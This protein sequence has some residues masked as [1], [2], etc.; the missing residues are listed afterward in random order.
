MDIIGVS[1]INLF[2]KTFTGKVS[3]GILLGN[4]DTAYF[5]RRTIFVPIKT[6]VPAMYNVGR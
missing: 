4:T 3:I 1:V 2:K 6:S 5:K